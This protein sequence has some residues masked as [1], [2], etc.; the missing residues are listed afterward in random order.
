MGREDRL[1][2]FFTPPSIELDFPRDQPPIELEIFIYQLP[3]EFN[4][5]KVQKLNL[6]KRIIFVVVLTSCKSIWFPTLNLSAYC[7]ELEKHI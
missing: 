3:M 2:F 1:F 7:L 5:S 6:Q 4:L